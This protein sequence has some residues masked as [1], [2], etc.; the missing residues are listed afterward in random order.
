MHRREV[1]MLHGR[2]QTNTFLFPQIKD[3]DWLGCVRLHPNEWQVPAAW[4]V[5]FRRENA[6]V[7][8]NAL[9]KHG[10]ARFIPT[11]TLFRE[12]EDRLF[13]SAN[14]GQGGIIPGYGW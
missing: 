13:L 1:G 10:L 4:L 3:A 9:R 8:L 14:A 11:A 5:M 12:A 7:Y 6:S 2:E